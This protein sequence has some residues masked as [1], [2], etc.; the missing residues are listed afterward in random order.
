MVYFDPPKDSG[1]RMELCDPDEQICN[2]DT[3]DTN[4]KLY[5]YYIDDIFFSEGKYT[6][7][8]RLNDQIHD[9]IDLN[10]RKKYMFGKVEPF[11]KH[12]KILP[13]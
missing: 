1:T 5:N 11:T 3:T 8:A 2:N 12:A 4:L 10:F 13:K 7:Q 6:F 9:S